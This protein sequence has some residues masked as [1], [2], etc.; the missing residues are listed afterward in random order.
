MGDDLV[1]GWPEVG[2]YVANN[3]T[4][5]VDN[6]MDID[7]IDHQDWNRND[8]GHPILNQ[9]HD[10][11]QMFRDAIDLSKR[12]H[13][14]V[15]QATT[16][17]TSCHVQIKDPKEANIRQLEQLYIQTSIPLYNGSSVSMILA[18]VVILNMCTTHGTSNTFQKIT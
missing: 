14:D 9:D 11:E 12:I 1:G 15:V 7:N 2:M 4:E 10:V 17:R 8:D 3:G 5:E 13:E 16:S 18:I 6:D